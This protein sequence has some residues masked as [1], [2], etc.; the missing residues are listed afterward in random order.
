MVGVIQHGNHNTIHHHRIDSGFDMRD[1]D[2]GQAFPR[3]VA[4]ASSGVIPG[5]RGM[6]LR[7]YFAGQAL[8][9]YSASD[10]HFCEWT[11]RETADQAYAAA[12]AM[13]AER[14]KNG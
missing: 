9:G 14:D 12:D 8:A 10:E 3:S 5:P 11:H 4:K 6:T 7:D 2:G 1:K 13:I